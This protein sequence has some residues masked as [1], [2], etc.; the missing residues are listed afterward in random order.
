[1]VFSTD[2]NDQ[3]SFTLCVNTPEPAENDECDDAIVLPVN[4]GEECVVTTDATFNGST[5]S[6]GFN[7]T[8]DGWG[9]PY[10]DVWFRFTATSNTHGISLSNYED[11]FDWSI[12]LEIFSATSCEDLGTNIACNTDVNSQ[13][14]NLVPGNDYFIRLYATDMTINS[15]FTICINSLTAPI[16]VSTTDYTVEELVKDVLVGNECLVSNISWSTGTSFSPTNGNGI[17]YFNSNGSS[18]PLQD[19][20]LLSTGNALSVVGPANGPDTSG[21]GW[22]GDD[23]LFDYMIAQGLDVDDYNDA[24]ILEFDFVP[25]KP[26]FSFD[27]IFASNEYGT[28]QCSFSDAFAF[29]LTD[30]QAGTTTNLAVV[31]GSN[32]PISVT[33]IRKEI[34]SPED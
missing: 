10:K 24:T 26:D 34:H 12:G 14:N 11:G 13:V 27:F 33:T 9:T 8:C 28:Y 4:D 22:P 3:Q 29:F 1:R 20:I 5:L 25:T 19:G 31:P 16:Y 17:G 23:Q 18:F 21:G 2:V 32:A 7:T 15:D 6:A 30:V